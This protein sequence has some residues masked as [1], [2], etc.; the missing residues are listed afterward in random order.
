MDLRWV[1]LSGSL[2]DGPVSGPVWLKRDAPRGW[3]WGGL[4]FQTLPRMMGCPFPVS[5]SQIT[6]AEEE[7]GGGDSGTA[8]LGCKVAQRDPRL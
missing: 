2:V 8:L 7:E 3:C 6:G 5:S 1:V 4:C